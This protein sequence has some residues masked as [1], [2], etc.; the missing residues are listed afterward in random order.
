MSAIIL[1]FGLFFVYASRWQETLSIIITE[2]WFAINYF[3]FLGLGI[4]IFLL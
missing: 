1:S 3:N 4:E 2:N